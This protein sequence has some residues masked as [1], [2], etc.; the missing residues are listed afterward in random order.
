MSV[1]ATSRGLDEALQARLSLAICGLTMCIGPC[2][3]KGALLCLPHCL[4]PPEMNIRKIVKKKN[5]YFLC[6]RDVQT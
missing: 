4:F 2:D 3:C 1:Q 5:Q 6:F